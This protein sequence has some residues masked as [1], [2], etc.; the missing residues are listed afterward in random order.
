M[1]TGF[2]YQ[3]GTIQRTPVDGTAP[4][5][6]ASLA[7]IFAAATV[8]ET[9][10]FN[11]AAGH[12]AGI[13]TSVSFDNLVVGGA[14]GGGLEGRRVPRGRRR[15]RTPHPGVRGAARVLSPR[16]GTTLSCERTGLHPRAVVA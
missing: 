10:A 2:T 13:D 14:G 3:T 1:G 12:Y 16:S 11:N 6:D 4:A 9:D 8:A 5:D 7:T 15:G